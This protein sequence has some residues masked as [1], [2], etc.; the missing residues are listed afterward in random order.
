MQ[1]EPFGVEQWMNRWETRCELNL[2]E[3]CVHSLSVGEL[4]D[5]CGTPAGWQEDLASLRLTYGAIPGSGRLRRA[6]AALYQ[7][8]SPSEVLVTHGAVGAN[9]LV[10]QALVERGDRVVSIVPTYQQHVAIPAALGADLVE[11]PLHEA[12]GWRLDLD[13]LAAAATPGTRLIALANPNNPTGALLSPEALAEIVGIARSAGAWLLADEVYRG[14]AQEGDGSGPSV[15]DLY[16]RGLST[17][18]MSKSFALA[19]L[20]LG[21]IAGPR[22]ALEAVERHRD[23]TTISVGVVD[24]WLA[25]LALEHADGAARPHAPDH[26]REPRAGR[27]LGRRRTR[28]VVGASLGGDH[29]AD[30]TATRRGTPSRSAPPSSRRPVSCW[31]PVLPSGSRARSGSGSATAAATWKRALRGFLDF[32]AARRRRS[33]TGTTVGRCWAEAL[34]DGVTS[35]AFPSCGP[36]RVAV[37]ALRLSGLCVNH[38]GRTSLA[39][40]PDPAVRCRASA[41]A[42]GVSV[43]WFR[44]APSFRPPSSRQWQPPRWPRRPL[45]RLRSAI[46][47]ACP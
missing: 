30:P 7:R 6:I 13:L 36:G 15:A 18:S 21:W 42:S 35:S 43:S 27:R 29:R 44:F 1:I 4:I 37:R 41:S 45:S 19:G 9:H 3:T 20:R 39:D 10:Y 14:T 26:A 16:E 33:G 31:F 22:E 8:Q 2:A 47:A 32:L 28:P 25:A 23:Y 40:R 46:A 24:D 17:G 34:G 5:L 38:D 11:V 12:S